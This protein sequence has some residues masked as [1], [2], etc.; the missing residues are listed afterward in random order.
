M[1]DKGLKSNVVGLFAGT[2]LGIYSVAPAYGLTA[3]LG[4]LAV[5]VGAKTPVV[6]IGGFLP[7]FT[8]AYAYRE[9]NKI[10]LDDGTSFT[11]NLQGA[12]ALHRLAGHP[13]V[14]AR[15]DGQARTPAQVM[16]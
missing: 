4:I 6:I 13:L 16:M 15:A 12:R 5:S 14:G 1:A 11:W 9:F 8:A 7:M 2:M 3:T 10:M